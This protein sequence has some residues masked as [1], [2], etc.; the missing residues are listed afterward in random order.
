MALKLTIKA[1]PFLTT[2][3]A[4]DV[5]DIR[6]R[7]QHS[8]AICSGLTLLVVSLLTLPFLESARLGAAN[9]VGIKP[10]LLWIYS[11]AIVI[12]NFAFSYW[13]LS[14]TI[15]KRLGDGV[16]RADVA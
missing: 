16:G 13:R 3:E 7:I 1:I 2:T 14:S 15:A 9:G 8:I 11:F 6:T 12:G 4:I 10:T 5:K